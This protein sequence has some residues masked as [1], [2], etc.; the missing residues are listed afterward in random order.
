MARF[1]LLNTVTVTPGVTLA[2]GAVVDDPKLVQA[3]SAAGGVLVSVDTPTGADAVEVARR[4]ADRG[5]SLGGSMAGIGRLAVAGGGGGGGIFSLARVDCSVNAAY[6]EAPYSASPVLHTRAG[7]NAVGGYNGTGVGNKC[8]LGF[9]AGVG[10]AIGAW[11][12]LRWTWLD[13]APATP[14]IGC[15]S[16]QIVNLGGGTIKVF[17]VDPGA[18]PALNNG[19]TVINGDGSRT[20]TFDPAVHF[21][22]VVN[23]VV[24]VV[25]AVDLGGSWTARSYRVSDI[26]AVYPGAV[27][28]NVASGDGGMPAT[29]VATPPVLIVTGDSTNNRV[30]AFRLSAVEFNG[31]A[32]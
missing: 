2:P 22:T 8:I 13:L 3:A 18:N 10:T 23:D 14:G 27:F 21:V 7:G 1:G 25:P 9:A 6:V 4:F 11:T 19:V 32:V 20:T 17:V 16:N 12:G 5:D 29:P 24:G 31:A 26:L 28:A 15:Y 30:R